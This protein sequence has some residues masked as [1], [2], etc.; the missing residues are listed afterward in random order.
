M[1]A[2]AADDDGVL[3]FFLLLG[4]QPSVLHLFVCSL[5]QTD[6]ICM[7]EFVGQIADNAAYELS[8]MSRARCHSTF[9]ESSIH[10]GA[11]IILLLHFLLATRRVS[12]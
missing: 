6:P 12:R 1:A 7:H 5:F 3:P 9:A 10:Y 2:A 4:P 11:L 8:L